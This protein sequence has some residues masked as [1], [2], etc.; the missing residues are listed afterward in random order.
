MQKPKRQPREIDPEL[1]LLSEVE[2]KVMRG[3][4]PPTIKRERPM[5]SKN[6]VPSLHVAD[7]LKDWDVSVGLPN[8]RWVMARSL[9]FQALWLK[10]RLQLAWGVFTGRYDALAWVEQE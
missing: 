5:F 2:A 4:A 7:N 3:E 6:G 9:G 1:E 8:G 10:R